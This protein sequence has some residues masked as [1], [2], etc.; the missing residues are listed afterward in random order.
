EGPEVLKRS[1]A[2]PLP[3]LYVDDGKAV[4]RFSEIF[5]IQEPPRKGE[6]KERRHSTP[7]DRYKSLDLSDDIVEEDEE[8]FLKSFSQSLT[9]SKQVCVAHTDVSENNNVDLEFPKFG[10][11]HGDASLTVKDD[12]QPKDSCL[13]GE[14]M[15]G[16]FADDLSWKDHPLM[17]A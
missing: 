9:L 13:G 11:L 8:E 17:L 12:R 4:L 1:M 6:K 16:D 14:P 7:R 3:V 10:F 15:K 5:G 2:T